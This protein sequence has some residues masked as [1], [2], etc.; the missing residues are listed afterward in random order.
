M[1]CSC[2]S[3]AAGPLSSPYWSRTVLFPDWAYRPSWSPGSRQ[4]QLWHFL[5]ELL[6]GGRPGPSAGGGSGGSS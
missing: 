4:V 3:S 2:S 5:L 1:Q 6:G